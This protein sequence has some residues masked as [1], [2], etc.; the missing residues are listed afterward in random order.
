[1]IQYLRTGKAAHAI[2]VAAWGGM[3]DEEK[4]AVIGKMGAALIPSRPSGSTSSLG[5]WEAHIPKNVKQN[6]QKAALKFLK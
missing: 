3:D 5:H 1:M 6:H 2:A 4:S